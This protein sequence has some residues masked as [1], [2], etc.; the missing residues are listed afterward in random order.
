MRLE[1][2]GTFAVPWKQVVR[3]CLVFVFTC[4]LYFNVQNYTKSMGENLKAEPVRSFNLAEDTVEEFPGVYENVDPVMMKN[5]FAVSREMDLAASGTEFVSTGNLPKP[6]ITESAP[7]EN[8][9]ISESMVSVTDVP[10]NFWTFDTPDAAG[11]L[12]APPKPGIITDPGSTESPGIMNPG[13]TKN[14]GV[15]DPDFTGNP[16]IVDPGFTENS[17]IVDP[18]FTENPGIQ[19]P[20]ITDPGFTENPGITDPGSTEEP[21]LTVPD[22]IEKPGETEKS[23]TMIAED[24][25]KTGEEDPAEEAEPEVIDGFMVDGEGYITGCTEQVVIIDDILMFPAGDKCIGIRSGALDSIAGLVMEVYIPAN[26][27]NIETG[28]FD[29]FSSLMYVEAAED[30]PGC[31]SRDGVLYAVSGEIL[32]NPAGR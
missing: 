4:I 30:N 31:Y 5:P 8:G 9:I 6:K 16:G 7:A 27:C 11:N 32:A 21:G 19:N 26:I 10:V 13:I 1:I 24:P 18:G 3:G 20:G 22:N 17:G 15:A 12:N 28:V 25:S 14:P 2:P 29:R 23:D